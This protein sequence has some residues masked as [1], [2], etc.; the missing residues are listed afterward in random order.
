MGNRRPRTMSVLGYAGLRFEWKLINIHT[1]KGPAM[2]V[3][4]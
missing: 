1:F 2:E 3:A 4:Q